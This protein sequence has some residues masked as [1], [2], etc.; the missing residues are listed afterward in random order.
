M[1]ASVLILCSP[2]DLNHPM[3]H[4]PTMTPELSNSRVEANMAT[5]RNLPDEDSASER[6]LISLLGAHLRRMEGQV[7]SLGDRLDRA[8]SELRTTMDR[9][10]SRQFLVQILL[11][12]VV[13]AASGANLMITYSRTQGVMTAA[14]GSAATPPPAAPAPV[15]VPV[16]IDP[17]TTDLTEQE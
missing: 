7:T 1:P 15:D 10:S 4:T 8:V 6:Q 14:T 17:N 16:A 12:L 5:R 3:E 9:A 2:T 11:I 13:A